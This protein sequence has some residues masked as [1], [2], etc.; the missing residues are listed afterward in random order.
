MKKVIYKTEQFRSITV[1]VETEEQVQLVSYF[2]RDFERI[3]RQNRRI[4][5]RTDSIEQL[6]GNVGFELVDNGASP[7]EL[8][9]QKELTETVAKAVGNLTKKQKAVIYKVFWED[10]SLREIAREM[11]VHHSSVEEV[12]SAGLKKM[13]KFLF[14]LK[15]TPPKTIPDVHS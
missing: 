5:A 14:F 6:S 2:N 13:K 7:E 4:R 10:K 9:E 3:D 8:Y 15:N 11:K 1:E 12:Y